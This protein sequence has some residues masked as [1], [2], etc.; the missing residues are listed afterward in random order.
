MIIGVVARDFTSY[1]VWLSKSVGVPRNHTMFRYISEPDKVRGVTFDYAIILSNAYR[2]HDY[3]VILNKVRDAIKDRDMTRLLWA[4]DY[5]P[6]RCLGA[7]I[8]IGRGLAK[9]EAT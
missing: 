9:Y 5:H 3:I 8:D 6:E 4:T 2:K 1:A 7:G